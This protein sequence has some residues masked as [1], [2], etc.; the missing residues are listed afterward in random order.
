MRD[1][2]ILRVVFSAFLILWIGSFLLYRAACILASRI[3][4]ELRPLR[5]HRSAGPTLELNPR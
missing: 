5:R 1:S 4:R 3:E 2:P